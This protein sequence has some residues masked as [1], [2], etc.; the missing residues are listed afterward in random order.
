MA[1]RGHEGAEEL[2]QTLS[3]CFADL[4]VAAY[5]EGGSLMKFGGDALFLL[6]DGEGHPDRAVSSALQMRARLA[7]SGR[8]PT[9]V[10]TIRLRMSAGVHSGPVHLFRVGGSHRELLIAGPGPS[11]V[12]LME[13]TATAG[14]IVV[15]PETARRVSPRLVGAAAGPGY[16]LRGRPPISGD[17]SFPSPKPAEV[18]LSSAVPLALRD[19]LAASVEPE[20]RQVAVAFIRFDGVDAVIASEGPA[21]AAAALAEVVGDVQTA[22]DDEGVTVLGTDADRDGGK[23]IV[24]AGAPSALDDGEGR[25]LRAMRRV[26]DATRK[27]PVRVGVHQ[28][29]AFVGE[30]GPGYRRTY[31]AMGDTVNLA[32]RL[33]ASAV[34]GEL[35]ATAGVLD[36][37]ATE[38]ETTELPPFLVKGKA[39]PVEAF[40]VGERVRRRTRAVTDLPFVGRTNERWE[41]TAALDRMRTGSGGL[42]DITGEAGVG[43]SRLLRELLAEAADVPAVTAYCETY[44][45]KTPYFAA[46][47]L[48]RGALG[49]KTATAGAAAVLRAVVAEAAPDLLPWLPLVGG[50]IDVP[51]PATPE[52]RALE[53]QFL[54]EQ[55][56]RVVIDVL[57]AV[58]P[59]QQLFVVEDAQWVDDLSA[60]I[61]EAIALRART[62]R[63]LV[64]V[65]RRFDRGGYQPGDEA[66][67]RIL[68]DPLA[69]PDAR[70]LLLSAAGE[71]NLLRPDQI[72]ALV[73]R[74]GGNPLFIEQL[75]QAAAAGV[76]DAAL[77][78][79]LE[80]V[81][82]AQIDTLPSHDR[83]ALR[84]AAVLGPMFELARL[85]E[86]VEADGG[87]VDA[88][89]RRLRAFLERAAPGWLRF[90]NQCYREVAYETLSFRK[91]KELHAR[92]GTAIEAVMNE[93]TTDRSEILSFHFLH[94]QE[95]AKCWAYA[96][97]AGER[98]KEKFANVEAAALYER[99]LVAGVQ[100]GEGV[101]PP[102]A[103]VYELLGDAAVHGGLFE[104]AQGA[105][106]RARRLT[107][108]SHDV[109]RLCKLE[110]VTA[111]HRGQAASAV[112]WI[113]RAMRL[114]DGRS[115]IAGVGLRA[116]IRQ[117][118][119]EQLQRLR[120]NRKA[121]AW[122]ELAIADALAAD[123]R[124]ALA[125]AYSV[126]DL[127]LFDLGRG[128]EATH[129]HEALRIWVDLGALREQA[130]VLTI[131]GASAYWSGEWD[132]ALE[133]FSRG[134]DAYT[135][136]GDSVSAGY[137]TSNIADI[138][139]DQGRGEEVIGLSEVIQLWRSVGHPDPVA[140]ALNNL[141]RRALQRGDV[142]KAR[143]LF[144]QARWAS[145][146]LGADTVEDDYWIAECMIREGEAADALT[147]LDHA[148]RAETAR[149]STSF[150]ARLHRAR[151]YA[152]LALADYADAVGEFER[153]VAS[154]RERAAPYEV[155][156]GL[157]GL[158]ASQRAAGVPV[159]PSSEAERA[160]VFTRLGV[161]ASFAPLI[162]SER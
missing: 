114:L 67:T 1:R 60:E 137:G 54:R 29:H 149:G 32:A 138:L 11:T 30:V 119:A 31:T 44:E 135:K 47:Y 143:D 39:K 151:G 56:T 153:A 98:A 10:G 64:C 24:V 89:P 58:V 72:G 115:D 38:F 13:Q 133:Y 40:L 126:A 41:L 17:A 57:D 50:V 74:A 73:D 61:L 148:L 100:L 117:L 83:R 33:M 80:S 75:A 71:S 27:L 63:W 25:V 90:R 101:R 21:A 48:L 53:P 78:G 104:R 87:D 81:V 154:A 161:R 76:E 155:A 116:E 125:H 18:D 142:M 20:H 128:E 28:G 108:D 99:A 127:A 139:L 97:A 129:L 95:Y 103:E 121:L 141:G 66:T 123:N 42:V 84:Y 52:T 37:A 34:A 62:R 162:A 4:L 51:V 12:V 112:R 79:S 59:G 132:Q 111:M 65:V 102:L 70:A 130:T 19:H 88:T 55:T 2:T 26:V 85:N 109:A 16:F 131:L 93:S 136:A 7:R 150:V 144:D 110:S 96:L 140:G 68:L 94:A 15:S 6:Y 45:A 157:E 124:R 22:V 23:I 36:R 43:K 14:Q 35:R 92:A 156:L 159:D 49:I 122:A 9:S 86:L 91:R 107:S 77:S 152:L 3:T 158:A 118:R 113:N 82:A 105:F 147:L 106:R 8:I 69:D 134:R 46:R 120:H 145:E 146:D 5:A 160:E